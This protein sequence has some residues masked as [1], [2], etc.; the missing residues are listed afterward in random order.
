MKKEKVEKV[1]EAED[2]TP[3]KEHKVEHKAQH[4]AVHPGKCPTCGRD[5]TTN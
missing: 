2:V 1:I 5:M 3:A 4:P